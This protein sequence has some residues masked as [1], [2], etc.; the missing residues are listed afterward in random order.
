M[1][2]RRTPPRRRKSIRTLGVEAAHTCALGPHGPQAPTIHGAAI[3]APT[4]PT[5]SVA[6]SGLGVAVGER[7]LL[8]LLDHCGQKQWATAIPRHDLT[9]RRREMG[10]PASCPRSRRPMSGSSATARR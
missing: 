2:V 10:S 7:R 5:L 4:L 9:Y 3:G 8:Y 1:I 6:A